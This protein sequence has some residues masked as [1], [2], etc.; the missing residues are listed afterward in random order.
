MIPGNAA[1]IR[2]MRFRPGQ[3]LRRQSD[4]RAVRE[5]GSRVDCQ[6]FTVWWRLRPVALD[7]APAEQPGSPRACVV[8]STQAVGPAV[9]RNRAKRRLREIFRQQQGLLPA[10]CDVLLVARGAVNRRPFPELRQTFAAACGRIS[11]RASG[12]KTHD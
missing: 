1:A 4:I 5:H 6:S 10:G 12:S 9:Q 8:A 11:S 2:P 3:H 7:A